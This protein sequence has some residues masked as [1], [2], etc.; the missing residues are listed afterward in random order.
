MADR[1]HEEFTV[2]NPDDVR[3]DSGWTVEFRTTTPDGEVVRHEG[4]F[5]YNGD[6]DL[7][8][9][10]TPRNGLFNRRK[11]VFTTFDP[12]LYWPNRYY[13]GDH[14]VSVAYASVT[15]GKTEKLW[16]K[17]DNRQWDFTLHFVPKERYY[18]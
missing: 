1:E 13:C 12:G 3:Y 18:G 16:R 4:L 11:E 5:F 9:T 15:A 8:F 6:Y 10:A 14:D 2:T 17:F 7:H